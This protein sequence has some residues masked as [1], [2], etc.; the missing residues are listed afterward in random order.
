VLHTAVTLKLFSI[1]QIV[2]LAVLSV[3]LAGTINEGLRLL[4]WFMVPGYVI[5][6]IA[7]MRGKQ[8]LGWLS[9]LILLALSIACITVP[10]LVVVAHNLSAFFNHHELYRDSPATIYVVLIHF[11]VFGVFPISLAILAFGNRVYLLGV[12]KG[13]RPE[14]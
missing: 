2:W 13:Y 6:V 9:S 5:A 8:R 11:L 3:L 14:I 12:I 1:I 10:E 4:L 7:L